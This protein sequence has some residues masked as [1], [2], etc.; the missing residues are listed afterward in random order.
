MCVRCTYI[1]MMHV[2][3]MQ[4]I[5]HAQTNLDLDA[6]M[7]DACI[8]DACFFSR[9]IYIFHVKIDSM[10]LYPV[11]SSMSS[12]R[13]ESLLPSLRSPCLE[14]N[15]SEPLALHRF[16]FPL[17]TQPIPPSVT[18]CWVG[19]ERKQTRKRSP[20]IPLLLTLRMVARCVVLD[21]I[22]ASH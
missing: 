20:F 9:T 3:M 10:A 15:L 17:P 19:V 22:V 11:A 6:C 14:A 12:C 7:H 8:H 2:F 1:C 18:P 21:F 13:L 5:C 4:Q 16:L